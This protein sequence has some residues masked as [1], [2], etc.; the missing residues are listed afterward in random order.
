MIII[1]YTHHYKFSLNLKNKPSILSV[2]SLIHAMICQLYQ[3]I[4]TFNLAE[5]VIAYSEWNLFWN[6]LDD[7]RGLKVNRFRIISFGKIAFIK[8]IL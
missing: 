8:S 2:F 3:T 6:K 5:I 1:K 7:D 4:E